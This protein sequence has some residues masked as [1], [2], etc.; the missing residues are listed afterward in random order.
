MEKFDRKE[1]LV[2]LIERVEPWNWSEGIPP[3]FESRDRW[4]VRWLPAWEDLF[5][6]MS[7]IIKED[8]LD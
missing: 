1:S 4:G 8:K 3:I 2:G 6:A 7:E 5:I